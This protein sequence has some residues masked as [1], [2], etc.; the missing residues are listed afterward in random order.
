MG[1]GGA[2]VASNGGMRLTLRR[3]GLLAGKAARVFARRA[4]LTPQR[5]DLMLLARRW[6]LTQRE[7]AERLCVAPS[8]IS[9]MIAALEGDGL[10]FRIPGSQPRSKFTR[11]TELGQERLALCFPEPTTRG[12]QATGEASWL[13]AWRH[14]MARNGLRVDSILRAR[15]PVSFRALAAWNECYGAPRPRRRSSAPRGPAVVPWSNTFV[16]DGVEYGFGHFHGRPA[17]PRS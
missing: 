9:R 5:V 3:L 14:T 11:L 16:L 6:D 13:D 2:K 7:I 15:P 10:V 17:P 1:P 8:V 4:R 12:A